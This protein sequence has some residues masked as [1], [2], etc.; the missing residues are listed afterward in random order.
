MIA[1]EIHTKEP[2]TYFRSGKFESPSADWMH[3]DLT[4]EDYELIVMTKG[5]LY[6]SCNNEKF[7]VK[8]N[9][10]LLLPPGKA[11]HYRRVGYKPS[12]C[13]FYWIHFLTC[14]ELNTLEVNSP[15]ELDHD[16]LEEKGQLIVPRHCV[17]PQI[18]KVLILMR[19]LQ[20]ATRL[21]YSPFI[22]NYMSTVILGEIYQQVYRNSA[23]GSVEKKSRA[24]I[25]NDIMDYISKN[26]RTKLT[27][28]SIATHFGYN[29][30]YLS[31]M[32]SSISKM[33]LKQYIL[34]TKMNEANFL[35]TDTNLSIIEISA[36]LGFS[37]HHHF[38][39]AYKKFTGLTPTEYRNAFAKRLLYHV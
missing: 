35:L 6:L 24:Q 15:T 10:M 25:Y 38:M 30:K 23:T 7:E 9:E 29:E 8:E 28:S 27:V 20:D 34:K 12:D 1:F 16:A 36:E 26:I 2:I 31:H 4:L 11:P 14:N 3:L 19:Q 37:D 13:S 5:T 22:L 18:E 33:P 17:L 39:K 32:F 21:D